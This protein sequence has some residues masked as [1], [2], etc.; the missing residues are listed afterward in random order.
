MNRKTFQVHWNFDNFWLTLKFNAASLRAICSF[1]KQ[2][3]RVQE[4]LLFL[5]DIEIFDV[6][7]FV[8]RIS[9]SKRF[10]QSAFL[11]LLLITSPSGRTLDGGKARFAHID[12]RA[13][14]ESFRHNYLYKLDGVSSRH[15]IP[16]YTRKPL[17]ET[18]RLVWGCEEGK[19][20]GIFYVHAV[21]QFDGSKK[22]L[23]SLQERLIPS[24]VSDIW[25]LLHF[26][27]IST[28]RSSGKHFSIKLE[29]LRC[30]WDKNRGGSDDF[31][32][33]LRGKGEK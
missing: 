21:P 31:L 6:S 10:R 22:N 20:E 2:E 17:G 8:S 5:I 15:L 3:T 4:T 29:S 18:A 16:Y 11:L 27:L 25:F 32:W 13:K 9:R 23:Q 33:L 1:R 19:R 30:S 26:L 28:A 14:E 24:V 7:S 12:C